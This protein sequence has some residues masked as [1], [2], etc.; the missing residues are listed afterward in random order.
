MTFP[1]SP[2]VSN[3]YNMYR[4][5]YPK[6]HTRYIQESVALTDSEVR[7]RLGQDRERRGRR[8]VRGR[9][10]EGEGEGG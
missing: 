10:Q 2:A 5:Q 1:L 4:V 9:G 7:S 8:R 3:L 6:R